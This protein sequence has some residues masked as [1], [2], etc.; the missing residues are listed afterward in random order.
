[1]WKQRRGR[2]SGLAHGASTALYVGYI[3]KTVVVKASLH[4]TSSR[5]WVS[6]FGHGAQIWLILE[7]LRYMY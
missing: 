1:M 7:F 2:R 6:M 3:T 4:V 5:F